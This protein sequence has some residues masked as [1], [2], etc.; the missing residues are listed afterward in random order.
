MNIKDHIY[1]TRSKMNTQN[2]S[3]HEDNSEL[4]ITK[5]IRVYSLKTIKNT[6]KPKISKTKKNKIKSKTSKTSKTKKYKIESK[7]SKT[8]YT[9]VDNIF[10]E[11]HNDYSNMSKSTQNRIGKKQ[12]SN[13]FSL[14]NMFMKIN[15]ASNDVESEEEVKIKKTKNI[16]KKK[17]E[18]AFYN[19]LSE[20]DKAL[21]IS[22]E[23]TL[24]EYRS[25]NIPLRFKI[26][27]LDIP[28]YTKNYIIEKI[29]HFNKL[30][31]NDNEYHKLSNWLHN[32]IKIPFNTYIHPDIQDTSSS[33]DIAKYLKDAQTILEK[34]VYGHK[35]A[36]EQI[37]EIIA[38][39]IT[40]PNLLGV[41][42]GIQGPPGNGKTTLIKNGI[43][44]ALK[45][46]FRLIGLGGNSNS[47][48]LIGHDY[49]Y[50]GSVP[51]KIVQV[52]QETKCMNPIIYF[53][54]L[55]KVSDTPKGQEIINL[56]CH[57]VDTSQNQHF[58][59][60]YFSSIDLDMSR[61]LFVFS[62]NDESKIS[63]ILLDRFIKIKT[64]KF[65]KEDKV[66]IAND[67]LLPKI[68][69]NINFDHSNISF[70]NDCLEYII[71]NHTKKE[72]GV[73]NLK[74]FLEKIVSRVN[75]VNLL[76]DYTGNV[77]DIIPYAIENFTLPIVIDT[78]IKDNLI[79]NTKDD[80]DMDPSI[81]GLYT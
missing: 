9:S 6:S 4:G 23:K 40:N 43:S 2:R 34:E 46:P 36:K 80:D 68:C 1:F 21:Y 32:L 56:L 26:L 14:E 55:D 3:V 50:E 53:D 30:E 44:K 24:K 72:K 77:K 59:D 54:E 22:Y 17:E 64:N 33:E 18:R 63:P 67:Y 78:N 27:K 73:R 47:D 25:T 60:K 29:D 71:T 41:A 70:T 79:T 28:L 57:L 16:Y 66:T 19:S 45:R 20:E 81:F 69:K 52:L 31:T 58:A 76:K 5:P 12:S 48:F 8:K 51:G 13:M 38:S 35:E 61:V 49:T 75:I 11:I 37:I 7:M 10:Q 15:K 74:R 65:N 62:Y 42:I 39:Q